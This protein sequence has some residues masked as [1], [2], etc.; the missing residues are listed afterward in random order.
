MCA[1]IVQRQMDKQQTQRCY[2]KSSRNHAHYRQESVMCQVSTCQVIFKSSLQPAPQ[3][4][5]W[6]SFKMSPE[7]HIHSCFHFCINK[8]ALTCIPSCPHRN[9]VKDSVEKQHP[10]HLSCS[11]LVFFLF[12]TW[13]HTARKSELTSSVPVIGVITNNPGWAWHT[14]TAGKRHILSLQRFHVVLGSWLHHH[15]ADNSHSSSPW[16]GAGA[17]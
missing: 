11:R 14:T 5:A 1:Y 10:K 2:R 6:L 4:W 17:W 12:A 16:G 8:L 3:C 9:G 13:R 15:K 7:K